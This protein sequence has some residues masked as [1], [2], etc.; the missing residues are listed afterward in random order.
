[1]NSLMLN[2]NSLLIHLVYAE[3]ILNLEDIDIYCP[4]SQL[5]QELPK[6]DKIFNSRKCVIFTSLISCISEDEET[7]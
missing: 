5:V 6:L 4:V 3:I 2:C 1:M 7:H